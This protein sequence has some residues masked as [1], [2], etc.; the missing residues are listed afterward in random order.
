LRR[1]IQHIRDR[2]NVPAPRSLAAKQRARWIQ[3]NPERFLRPDAHRFIRHDAHRFFKPGYA[4]DFG[5]EL[6]H[7]RS[8][9]LIERRVLRR[10][11][12]SMLTSPAVAMSTLQSFARAGNSRRCA[13]NLRCSASSN[14]GA[15]PGSIWTSRVC[16]RV[17][18]TA[19]SG[20]AKGEAAEFDWRPPTSRVL[21][22][23]RRRRLLWSWQSEQSKP[24][25]RKIFCETYSEA[26]PGLS[27]I[28]TS[29]ARTSLDPT[30]RRRL[31]PTAT[32]QR[33]KV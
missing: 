13:S 7:L 25:G 24:I 10:H 16:R 31:I 6:S 5:D 11:A 33:L 22:A 27:R 8:G 29:T 17:I 12:N 26:K 19:G 30:R 9:P 28:Q 4:V 18:R 20:R 21:V 14:G 23:P 1:C 3:T 15:R 2:S 32:V